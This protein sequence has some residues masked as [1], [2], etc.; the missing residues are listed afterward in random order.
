MDLDRLK[1]I[2]DSFGHF[3]GDRALKRTAEALE[4]TLRRCGLDDLRSGSAGL[5]QCGFPASRTL[6]LESGRSPKTYG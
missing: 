3:E 2:N 5:S 4:K 6:L 1:Q